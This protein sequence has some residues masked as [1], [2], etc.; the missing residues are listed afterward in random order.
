MTDKGFW[1]CI[2]CHPNSEKIAIRNLK[3]QDFEYY[4]P[5]ILERR[6]KRGKV[7]M[8]EQPLFPCYLFVRIVSHWHSIRYTYGVASI[9]QN[10]PMPA[11]IQDSIINDLKSRESNGYIQLPKPKGFSIGDTVKIN[12]PRFEGQTALVE[13][14]SQTVRQKVL[15]AL[16]SNK[17]HV[18]IDESDVEKIG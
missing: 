8:V 1:S 7:R 3:N 16:L 11:I 2:R 12:D 4:Q 17:I 14:M 15:L 6:I 5:L 9:I 13:R 18:L 10:G